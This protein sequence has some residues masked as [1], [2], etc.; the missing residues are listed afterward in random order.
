MKELSD[1]NGWWLVAATV[2]G[3]LIWA[4]LILALVHL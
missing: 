3:T 2:V 4:L 1:I